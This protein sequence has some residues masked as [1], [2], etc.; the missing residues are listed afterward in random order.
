MVLKCIPVFPRSLKAPVLF[1]SLCSSFQS[2]DLHSVWFVVAILEMFLRGKAG[3]PWLIRHAC[4]LGIHSQME[5]QAESVGRLSLR[6][7]NTGTRAP[8]FD[9]CFNLP[10]LHLLWLG[11]NHFWLDYLH[12]QT[13]APEN[14]SFE[15][16][17]E[18]VGGC[19]CAILMPSPCV[20]VDLCACS[21]KEPNWI[22]LISSEHFANASNPA[23]FWYVWNQT[24][25]DVVR[26][27]SV[28][29]QRALCNTD[30]KTRVPPSENDSPL[31]HGDPTRQIP[32]TRNV[33]VV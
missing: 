24:R 20:N 22:R 30:S 1:S 14:S 3:H 8:S 7:I 23:H 4:A 31:L 26:W 32:G 16:N 21:T 12:L 19:L 15:R 29:S 10:F 25:V 13:L 33:C 11:G 5:G 27:P 18:G 2:A 9:M 6:K 28:I 17:I